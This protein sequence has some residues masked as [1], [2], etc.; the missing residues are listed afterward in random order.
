[1]QILNPTDLDIHIGKAEHTRDGSIIL[2]SLHPDETAKLK[3]IA[4]KKLSS[5]YDV[6]V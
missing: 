3:N 1:M 2:G 4:E 5:K 6:R